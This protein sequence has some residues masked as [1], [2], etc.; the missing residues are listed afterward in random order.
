MSLSDNL[1]DQFAKT[2]V[3]KD[4]EDNSTVVNATYLQINGK[5]YVQIDGSE[6]YTPVVSTVEVENNERVKVEIKDHKATI[7]N[8][9]SSPTARS[10]SVQDLKD[11]V[12]EQGNT[13]K[14]L[15]TTVQAQGS[16]IN[17]MDSNISAIESTVNTYGSII[18]TQE[19]AI[20]VHDSAISANTANIAINSSSIESQGDTIRSLNNTVQAQGT[21]I[22][23]MNDTIVSQG[24]N[25]TAIN[26]TLTSHGSQI[27]TN[28]ANLSIANANIQILDSGFTIQDGVLT[29]LSQIII[30]TLTAQYA[31]IDFAN[32]GMLAVTELFAKSGIIED[33]TVR[34]QHI[35]GELVGVTIK[36]DIIE[37]NTV[38]AD[39]LVVLGSDGLYYKLN[40]DGIDNVSIEQ[41]SKF[42][43][44]I[45][46]PTDW[47][48]D[49]D[50]YYIIVDDQ[51]EHVNSM[52][53]HTVDG[54]TPVWE[55]N[56]YYKL[57]SDY[58]SGLDGTNIVA[59]S[60]TADKV[61]VSDLVAFDATIGG[62]HIGQNSI[63]SGVKE[64]VSN[65]TAGIYLDDQGQ[66]SIGNANNYFKFVKDENDQWSLDLAASTVRFGADG[67]TIEA[68]LG[69]INDTITDADTQRE[70]IM[71]YAF[72][73]GV[74][75]LTI[76]E[77]N[78]TYFTRIDNDEIR[79]VT[80]NGDPKDSPDATVISKMTTNK[81]EIDNVTVRNELIIGNKFRFRPIENN[82]IVL[83][84]I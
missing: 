53:A 29:G 21:S 64:S 46:K 67:T 35:T 58:E 8:N 14:I 72:I 43:L 25:I 6:I 38:K 47:D 3:Q 19:A 83:E 45:A 63:Y 41:A 73:N 71:N 48:T 66:V 75:T 56:Y 13:I 60:I 55:A 11:E 37:G 61:Q 18:D 7:T 59:K 51:Y 16:Y 34:D 28:E 44:L 30:D 17:V 54:T 26:T 68:A 22:S 40:I 24:N 80:I 78:G 50:N 39:K 32:I 36:G 42:T 84:K 20:R 15:D 70:A 49:Y 1:V 79:F 4:K 69:H 82:G 12:D 62:F 33:L 74:A 52:N 2:I 65:T 76:G 31:Q 10:K 27:E 9:I 5:D 23:T 77:K 81:L 57:S